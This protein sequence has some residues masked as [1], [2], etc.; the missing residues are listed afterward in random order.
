MRVAALRIGAEPEGWR[1]LGFEVQ[2]DASVALAN[3]RLELTGAADVGSIGSW[4][5]EGRQVP[6]DIDGLPT[7][8][9][10]KGESE[11]AHANGALSIDHLVVVTPSLERTTGAF[12]EA[13]VECRRVR[14]A[15]AGVLQGF[16][17]VGD[18]LVEVVGS[19]EAEA[20]APARFWGITVEVEDIDASAEKLG[21]RLGA[22]KDAVQ[23]G[24]RIATVRPEAS[25]GL[26][27]ALI[28]QRVPGGG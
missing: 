1:E 4:V 28:T 12:L 26:P 15:G 16:F 27:L 18:L 6:S 13:G 17:L 5:L 11:V 22:I 23:P 7:D 10:P 9:G 14:E 20:E 2:P 19:P 25:G 21:E 3:T 8:S 24:R